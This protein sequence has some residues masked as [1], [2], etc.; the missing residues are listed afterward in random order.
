MHVL[1]GFAVASFVIAVAAHGKQKFSLVQVLIL[2][3]CVAFVWELYEFVKD[4]LINDVAWNGWSD[5]ISDFLN[6]AIGAIV[7]FFFFK[8]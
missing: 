5:T 7:A 3:L 4:V 8:K 2:Y 1:G 6:G